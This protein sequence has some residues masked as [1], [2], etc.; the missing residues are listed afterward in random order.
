MNLRWD[1]TPRQTGSLTVGRNVTLTLIFYLV[2]YSIAK[3]L[4]VSATP[5]LRRQPQTSQMKILL[6]LFAHTQNPFECTKSPAG[7]G[8]AIPALR[9]HHIQAVTDR[10]FLSLPS[11]AF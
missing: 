4:P 1:S 7:N 2:I 6:W 11:A 3:H 5:H 10:I 9:E 8:L